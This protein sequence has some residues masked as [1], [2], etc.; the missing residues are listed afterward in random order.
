M[1]APCL[2][3]QVSVEL[4][5]TGSCL[6]CLLEVETCHT[7]PYFSQYWTLFSIDCNS[8]IRALHNSSLL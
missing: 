7:G 1:T 2:D 8:V 5:A 3:A 6:V 4:L